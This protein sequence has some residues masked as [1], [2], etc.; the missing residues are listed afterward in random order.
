M[1]GGTGFSLWVFQPVK[2]LEYRNNRGS[3]ARF[4][5]TGLNSM[6]RMILPLSFGDCTQWS[7]DSSCQKG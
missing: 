5:L 3:G 2:A 7:N 1:T 6:Y 4:A